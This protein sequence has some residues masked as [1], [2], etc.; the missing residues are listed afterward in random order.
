MVFV[1]FFDIGLRIPCVEL[2][3]RVLRL[4]GVE[5]AQLTPNSLMKLG[6]FEWILRSIGTSGEERLFACS[7]TFMTHTTS[8]KKEEHGKDT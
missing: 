2:V 6:V 4:Y 5:L 1:T 8:Q 3:S 7:P